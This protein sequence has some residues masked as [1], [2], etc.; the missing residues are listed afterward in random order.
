M[1]SCIQRYDAVLT[2]T[3]VSAK[4][5]ASIFNAF[6]HYLTN[7]EKNHKIIT[8]RSDYIVL[9]ILQHNAR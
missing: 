3:N 9:H 4:R 7:G 1:D 5:A 8:S 2:G 6:H